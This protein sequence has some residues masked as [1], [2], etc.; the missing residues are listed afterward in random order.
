MISPVNRLL[1]SFGSEPRPPSGPRSRADW[2]LLAAL[3]MIA[4][5]E[6]AEPRSRLLRE[7]HRL[8]FEKVVPQIGGLLSDRRAYR[9][10][11]KSVAYLPDE[12]ELAS[13]LESAGFADVEHRLLSGGI[14]QLMTATCGGRPS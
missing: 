7:G 8:Y 1:R 12:T 4:L 14:A 13:Q 5:L 10:L 2:R 3:V 9:Y 11:P 6:V